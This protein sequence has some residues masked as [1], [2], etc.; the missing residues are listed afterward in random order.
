MNKEYASDKQKG[1]V[2]DELWEVVTKNDQKESRR[3]PDKYFLA[4]IAHKLTVL[5]CCVL[6]FAVVAVV[7]AC[8]GGLNA[9][10]KSKTFC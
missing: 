3:Y 6:V 7:C 1:Q 5:P 9:F 2:Y 8:L 4:C 10:K